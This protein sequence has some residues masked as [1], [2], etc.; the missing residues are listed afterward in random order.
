MDFL[1]ALDAD[2]RRF[3]F[4]TRQADPAAKVPTCPEWTVDDLI[5]HV[6][7]VYLHKAESIRLNAA[8]SPWPPD[9]GGETA[10]NLLRR[11]YSEL[12][13]EFA[14]RQADSPAH[15][16]YGPDQTVGFWIRRMAQETVIHRI[17]AEFAAG[18]ESAPIPDDL[19]LDGIDEILNIFLCWAAE[20]WPEDF[21]EELSKGDGS[22]AVGDFVVSWKEGGITAAR[23]GSADATVKG[24]PEALLRWLWRRADD[25]TIQIDGDE[26]KV[27]QFRSLLGAATQ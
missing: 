21:A 23:S 11:A 2:Y 7:H 6:G 1:S 17:D 9:L 14:A 5:S 26:A 24:S 4:A 16:W 20:Q 10:P 22:V 12:N 19:A 13:D 27:A 18:L 3:V 8:P 15:T 25:T